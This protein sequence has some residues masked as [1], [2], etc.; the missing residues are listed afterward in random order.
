[1][2]F[3]LFSV[4]GFL[5][6]LC[7]FITS[8]SWTGIAE[9]GNEKTVL[10]EEENHTDYSLND[11][12][13]SNKEINEDYIG[14]IVFNSGLIDLP[15]IQAKDVYRKD[16][17]LYTF[18]TEDGQ[19]VKDPTGFNGNSVYIWTS[20]KTGGYDPKGEGGSVFMDYRNELDDQN[21][22]IYGHH[23]ARDYDP[24]GNRQFTPLDLLLKEENYEANRSL[25]LILEN[26]TREYVITNIFRISVLNDYQIQ[27]VR[28]DMN[29]DLSGNDDPFFFEG[30]I[31]YMDE[32]SLYETGEKLNADDHIL[33]LITCIQ[34]QPELRQ[35]IVCRETEKLFISNEE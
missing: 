6:L 16:G 4:T 15:V 9:T 12:W 30:F 17:T 3:F 11:I 35:V 24:Q 28:T 19:L 18:Y 10:S 27:V 34:H 20:W 29:R 21:I 26:E 13:L 14:Q 8:N 7:L 25:K 1:M 31:D 33:T 2:I 22:I 23:F 5:Y 32:I